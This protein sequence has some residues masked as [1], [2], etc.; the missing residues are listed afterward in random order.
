[1]NAYVDQTGCIS[2]GLCVSMCPQV[3]VF[4]EEG[5]AESFVDPIPPG[6]RKAPRALPTA[7]PSASSRSSSKKGPDATIRPF[8]LAKIPIVLGIPHKGSGRQRPASA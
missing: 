1:M 5:K 8:C 4:N 7:V 3:F 6:R 2:C